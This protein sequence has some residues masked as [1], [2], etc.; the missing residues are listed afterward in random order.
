[1]LGFLL[2]YPAISISINIFFIILHQHNLLFLAPINQ[3][4]NLTFG[5]VLL[6]YLQLI[7]GKKNTSGPNKFIHYLPAL[8]VFL[9]SGFYLLIPEEERVYMLTKVLA[10]NDNYINFINL[11]LLVHICLYLYL[12][13][14]S[15]KNYEEK[16]LYWDIAETKISIKWQKELLACICLANV[17]LIL[18]Y[19]MP[20]IIT[21]ST[22]IYSD[23]VATPIA[24]LVIYLFILYKGLTYYVIYNQPDYQAFSEAVA[25]LNEFIE[26]IE[27]SQKQYKHSKTY[28]HEFA[29]Q[30]NT[31]LDMLLKV[32]KIYTQPKLKLHDVALS[33][34]ISPSVLS[35]F[36][37]NHLK[38]TFFEMVN[39]YRVEEAK[40]LLIHPDYQHYKI[41]YI[42]E[43]S[44]F[45]SR[46]SFFAVFK[47]HVG[48]TPQVF[49]DE[50][51][52]E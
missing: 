52:S 16:A 25:P 22:H 30:I 23:V 42:G 6:Y 48:K 7:Q 12:G 43:I 32:Q 27:I 21:G 29:N 1:M 26:E 15:V 38:M 45:N 4:I 3:G 24:A 11:F 36:I 34:N 37:N 49:K 8:I 35:N 19:L 5:P 9:S 44:G 28:E 17:I 41:E 20:I 46:A 13:W 33:L 40:Q 50:Y 39:H 14:K 18:A 10:G 51:F 47:K 2:L 31:N